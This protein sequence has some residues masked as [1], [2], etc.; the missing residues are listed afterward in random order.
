MYVTD[1]T[2]QAEMS[3]LKE[4]APSNMPFMYVTDE[5]SQAEMSWLKEEAP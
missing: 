4:A 5:T 2:S 1:E 3:W